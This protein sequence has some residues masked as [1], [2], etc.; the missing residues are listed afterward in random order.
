MR[1]RGTAL[2]VRVTTNSWMNELQMLSPLILKKLRELTG[3]EKLSKI[4]FELGPLPTSSRR[5]ARRPGETGTRPMVKF[6][7]AVLRALER[8][9]DAELRDTIE[10]AL[11]HRF[12]EDDG[13]D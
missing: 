12:G 10:R 2:I 6:P 13:S 3:F 4:H 11:S 1:L 7:D 5:L 8:V 9:E